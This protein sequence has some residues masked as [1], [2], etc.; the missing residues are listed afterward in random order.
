MAH[1]DRLL[2]LETAEEPIAAGDRDDGRPELLAAEG[3]DVAAERLGHQM[4]PVADAQDRHTAGPE[5]RIGMGRA[6][7][8]DAG[9]SAGEDHRR[10]FAGGD[11]MPWRV[12]GQ[13]F[14]VDAQLTDATG[15]ELAVLAAEVEDDDQVHS[16]RD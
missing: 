16:G 11:L 1:P 14:R 13:Q 8:V 15:D 9:R 4:Q 10:R 3:D 2:G 5:R 12:E 6:R 7:F